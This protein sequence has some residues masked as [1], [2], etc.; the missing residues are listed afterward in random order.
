MP[1]PLQILL[2]YTGGLS[3]LDH[4]GVKPSRRAESSHI[5][6]KTHMHIGAIMI[7]LFQREQDA[8][9]TIMLTSTTLL[10]VGG[11]S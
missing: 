11:A 10:H 8:A 9:L 7:M 3:P 6:K 5:M 4:E 2:I 1:L